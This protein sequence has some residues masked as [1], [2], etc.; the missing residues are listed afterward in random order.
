MYN[1]LQFD[2]QPE[3][4]MNAISHNIMNNKNLQ[5]AYEMATEGIGHERMANDIYFNIYYGNLE[6]LLWKLE[7]E[8]VASSH[9]YDSSRRNWGND[10]EDEDEEERNEDEEGGNT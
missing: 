8:R 5:E 4:L 7:K 9:A 6:Y 2:H 3:V 1:L 10:E